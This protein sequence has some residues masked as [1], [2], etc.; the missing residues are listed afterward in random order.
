MLNLSFARV[1]ILTAGVRGAM[2]MVISSL[3]IW[4]GGVLNII[5]I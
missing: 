1:D 5:K 4:H 2:A 3:E